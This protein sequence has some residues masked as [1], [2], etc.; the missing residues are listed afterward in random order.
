MN[1]HIEEV[2]SDDDAPWEFGAFLVENKRL[3]SASTAAR[4]LK[5]A[6]ERLPKT[7]RLGSKRF[8]TRRHV[9]EWKQAL[10]D[11]AEHGA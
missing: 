9:R 3:L 7:Y 11:S 8:T 10:A 4:W 1:P 6:P 2:Q 5:S